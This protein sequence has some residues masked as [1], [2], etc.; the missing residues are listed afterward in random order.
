[1]KFLNVLLVLMLFVASIGIVS[2][3]T[4]S[5]IL[6]TKYQTFD[7]NYASNTGWNSGTPSFIY[8]NANIY[9]MQTL[10][11]RPDSSKPNFALND[12]SKKVETYDVYYRCSS[13]SGVIL[14]TGRSTYYKGATT[15]DSYIRYDF[16]SYDYTTNLESCGYKVYV[17]YSRDSKQQNLKS[18]YSLLD[19]NPSRPY[20]ASHSSLAGRYSVEYYIHFQNKFTLTDYNTNQY[21]IDYIRVNQKSHSSQIIIKDKY[22]NTISDTHASTN[23]YIIVNKDLEPYT[24]SV[25]SDEFQKWYSTYLGNGEIP[26]LSIPVKFYIEDAKDGTVID[27]VYLKVID[28]NSNTV[29]TSILSPGNT[30]DLPVG[31]YY[32]YIEK[33]GYSVDEQYKPFA[34]SPSTTKI[35]LGMNKLSA[36][37]DTTINIKDLNSGQSLQGVSIKVYKFPENTIIRNQIISSGESIVLEQGYYYVDL[38]KTG[39]KQ[40]FPKEDNRITINSESD[41]SPTFLMSEIVTA[42]NSSVIFN[43]YNS[44]TDELI[45]N[46]FLK[47][48]NSAN[49]EIASDVLPTGA[50]QYYLIDGE[51]Y[52]VTVYNDNYQN[53]P[54]TKQI[55]VFG[56]Y[57]VVKIYLTP[58]ISPNEEMVEFQAKDYYTGALIAGVTCNIYNLDIDTWYNTTMPNG[59]TRV[60]LIYGHKYAV[61]LEKSGYTFAITPFHVVHT[62]D[63]EPKRVFYAYTELIPIAG[64]VTLT[65][66][67]VNEYGNV[68]PNV[69]V[70][71]SGIHGV[72]S[73]TYLN[74]KTNLQGYVSTN[75]PEFSGYR[76][77]A[78]KPGYEWSITEITVTNSSP[79]N[80]NIVL[81]VA[82]TPTQP[83]QPGKPGEAQ[84]TLTLPTGE[85][86]DNFLEYFA[87]HFGM[88]LGGGLEIGKLFMWLCFST[89]I[90]VFVAQKAKA[91]AQGFGAGAGIV[92]LFFTL[93]GWVPLWLIVFIVLIIGLL[94]GKMVYDNPGDN[95]GGR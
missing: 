19:Y 78:S 17:D 18:L 91:G 69:N 77:T 93:I 49:T 72:G 70:L 66:N 30:V 2:A 75:I 86:A 1:M 16:D 11:W 32:A 10:F 47:I 36:P 83:T 37:V 94:Y 39:Y 58:K 25:Y 56:D 54:V 55:K 21:K 84:P 33:I 27:N 9:K 38:Q 80:A 62:D 26:D 59:Y 20:L 42:G 31:N 51:T 64:N 89:V 63:A 6:D 71:V 44:V 40:V 52:S 24:I 90:G 45:P 88:V 65:I 22:R 13:A 29:Y 41:P 46:S 95:G 35:V 7:S 85:K 60:N 48:R 12:E 3:K 23:G 61:Y 50:G 8:T 5:E 34:V 28:D 67:T 14:G 73:Q 43:V 79:V 53:S 68:I 76:I 74:L 4:E 87:G 82:S 15:A 57:Q 81:L 92:T